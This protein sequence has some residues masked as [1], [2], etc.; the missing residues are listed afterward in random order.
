MIILEKMES[1]KYF[2]F[3]FSLFLFIL[4]GNLIGMLPYSFTWTSHIIVT[5]TISFLF[6]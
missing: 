6:L 1:V 2:S 4:L 3:V 5:F